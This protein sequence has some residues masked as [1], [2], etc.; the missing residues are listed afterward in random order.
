[1]NATMLKV[2]AITFM[3][4]DHIGAFL[5]PN[6]LIFR[7]IGRLAFPIFAY[8]IAEGYR[9]TGDLTSYFG[10]LF[11]FALISQLPFSM[12]TGSKT[13]LNIFFTLALGLYAIY[14]YDKRN[15]LRFVYLIAI[16]A[17]YANTDYGF[18]GVMLIFIFY[19]YRDNFK[20]IVKWFFILTIVFQG[21]IDLNLASLGFKE[22]ITH[23]GFY[24][25]LWMGSLL[26]LKRYNGEKGR[27]LK[28]L[29]YI[30]YP[31]HLGI[32]AIIKNYLR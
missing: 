18:F 6:I 8:F 31:L 24:Q 7:L 22:M 16:L 12:A 14:V 3:L 23:A 28:Y 1:M 30:F 19:K 25:F 29:F 21:M 20:E 13:Y 4:I 32:I 26:F 27:G 2:L 10:R 15:D 5:F 11:A 9:K 17:Q